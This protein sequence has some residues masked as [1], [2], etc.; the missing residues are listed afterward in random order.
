MQNSRWTFSKYT[1]IDISHIDPHTHT[2]HNLAVESRLEIAFTGRPKGYK[3]PNC[4]I[5]KYEHSEGLAVVFEIE[6]RIITRFI[7]HIV[8]LI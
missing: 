1:H 3:V 4:T 7:P 5:Y 2:F 6:T 8:S